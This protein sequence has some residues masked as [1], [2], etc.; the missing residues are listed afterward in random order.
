[1]TRRLL[2]VAFVF[3]ALAPAARADTPPALVQLPGLNAC[4][5]QTGAD[6]ARGTSQECVHGSGL[7][8]VGSVATSPDGKNGYAV[9]VHGTLSL[10]SRDPAT[11]ALA[12]LGCISNDGTDGGTGVCAPGRMLSV[13]LSVVVSPDGQNV[14]VA[15]DGSP[16]GIAIFNRDPATG[17]LTQPLGRA[18]CVA[19]AGSGADCVP[20]KNVG[21]TL[22]LA[23]SPDGKSL[24]A[25]D[26]RG[27]IA[28]LRRS[29]DGTL[30]Q[31]TDP[32][33]GCI[34]ED[35]NDQE[36]LQ[37][38]MACVDGKALSEPITLAVSPKGQQVYAADFGS[39]G[40]AVLERDTVT[41]ELSQSSGTEGCVSQNGNDQGDQHVCTPAAGL[42]GPG[43]LLVSPDGGQLYVTTFINGGVALFDRDSATGDL[44]Q[45]PGRAGCISEDGGDGEGGQNVCD[46][47]R[48]LNEA[49]GIA[50]SP[51]GTKLYVGSDI[52]T[53]ALA[54]SWRGVVGMIPHASGGIAFFDRDPASGGLQQPAGSAGCVNEVGGPFAPSSTDG[55]AGAIALQGVSS[56]ATSPDGNN[57]YVASSDSSAIAEF[58]PAPP[59]PPTPPR[60]T[61]A[62]TVSRLSITHRVFAVAK[63]ATPVSAR[64]R[65]TSFRFALSEP[66]SVTISIKR[67]LPGRRV[68]KHCVKRNAHNRHRR[69]CT[70]FVAAG[71]LRRGEQA[72]NDSVR[73]SGRIEKRALKPGKY[74]ATITATDTAGN[75][76]RPRKVAFRIVRA[77]SRAR[78]GSAPT[79]GRGA[80]A[81]QA[82]PAAVAPTRS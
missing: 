22:D 50:Q 75:A 20:G 30:S 31:S 42:A 7:G 48:G 12:P 78:D 9:S 5:S 54:S 40:L 44:T 38:P 57:L 16:G 11:G 39:S 46:V 81:A 36:N 73:F 80:R 77:R 32:R 56:L 19:E 28:V 8:E 69:A 29:P 2:F 60:D 47:G 62:P 49:F 10:M 41:G 64:A 51:D 63:A 27:G 58:G 26:D 79:R 61:T 65:G 45:Q 33:S 72:G 25:A 59:A 4:V 70:R 43:S 21:T 55:C 37:T 66:A 23:I 1:L 15:S 3:A 6:D 67:A 17:L 35:G 14:Y 82:A 24:Y 76:S 34:T 13:A 71:T 52:R 68:G 53:T 74:R 18:G